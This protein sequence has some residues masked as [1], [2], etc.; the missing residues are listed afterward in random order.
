MSGGKVKLWQQAARELREIRWELVKVIPIAVVV[1]VLVNLSWAPA[2]ERGLFTGVLLTGLVWIVSW[3]V[4]VTRDLGSR[5]NGVMAE[6]V[7]NEVCHSH[8]NALASLPSYKF[9]RF[10][11][12][13]V[14]VTHAAVYAVETKW[15][16]S[17]QD[18]RD[19]VRL[20]RRLFR[21][22]E[23]F[24]GHLKDK[25]IPESWIRGVLVVRGP[26]AKG[27]KSRVLDLGGG[28]Q[29]RVVSG[30]GFPEWLDGQGKG[31][32]GP[33]FAAQLIRELR[34]EN[35]EQEHEQQLEVGPVLRWLARVK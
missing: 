2:Y 14:L 15:R 8:P 23:Q 26:G 27:L 29:I 31:M 11:I 30:T 17:K 22:V 34:E 1:L 5:L 28:A 4:W 24:R 13:T 32:V 25:Q 20:G 16:S 6:D 33:D 3:T 18:H 19:L 9:P 35:A 10:D 12:D 7:T 21:D